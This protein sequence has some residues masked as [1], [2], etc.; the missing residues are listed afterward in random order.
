MGFGGSHIENPLDATMPSNRSLCWAHLKEGE[1]ALSD[2]QACVMLKPLNGQRHIT[3]KVQRGIYWRDLIKLSLR[4][5]KLW[6]KI[7]EMTSTIVP[8]GMLTLLNNLCCHPV[9]FSREAV[10]ARIKA[11]KVN[12]DNDSTTTKANTTK[13]A[14]N[15]NLRCLSFTLNFST[16]AFLKLMSIILYNLFLFIYFFG[17]NLAAGLDVG[18][19][20]GI[21]T[22]VASIKNPKGKAHSKTVELFVAAAVGN[23]RR[24]KKLAREVDKNGKGIAKTLATTKDSVGQTVLHAAAAEGM[25]DICKYLVDD[26]KLDIHLKTTNGATPLLRACMDGHLS[27]VAYLLRKGADPNTTNDKGLT[28][29]HYVAQIVFVERSTPRA[30]PGLYFHHVP[31]PLSAAVAASSLRCVELL[32]ES[33]LKVNQMFEEMKSKGEEAFRKK[34]YS[35]AIFWYTKAINEDPSNAIVLS[36]RSLCWARMKEGKRA[37]SDAMAC[38]TLK[39]DWPKAYYRAGAAYTILEKFDQAAD[40]FLEGLKLAPENEDLR[41]ALQEAVEARFKSMKA[42]EEK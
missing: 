10:E 34:D 29:L 13:A 2:A 7:M 9:I 14:S 35:S 11:M 6:T 26:L 25:T 27:T 20:M 24:L 1:R 40:V 4:T 19:E 37:L 33:K 5:A 32:I 28:P 12:E 42:N 23:L 21:A 16:F 41:N 30:E 15:G 8:T 38:I 22:T 39:P 17:V 31:T 18:K 3:G 36:N